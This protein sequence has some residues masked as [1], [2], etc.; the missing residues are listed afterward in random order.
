MRPDIDVTA[1]R[2]FAKAEMF[3]IL[4]VYVLGSIFDDVDF[5]QII[6][7]LPHYSHESLRFGIHIVWVPVVLLLVFDTGVRSK[8]LRQSRSLSRRHLANSIAQGL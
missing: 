8:H 7:S 5:S 1:K 2:Y 6:F 3:K 4:F